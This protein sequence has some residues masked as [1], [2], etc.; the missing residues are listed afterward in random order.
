MNDV[1][2]RLRAFI[3]EQFLRGEDERN[4]ED[5]TPL[6]TSGIIDSLGT[7][8]LVTYV[9]STFGIEIEAHETGVEHFD[10]IADI[11]TLVSEKRDAA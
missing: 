6:R 10:C 11:A 7:L 9:E 8:Q 1:R 4:L 3:L 2:D 5:D